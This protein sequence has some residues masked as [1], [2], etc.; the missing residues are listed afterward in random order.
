MKAKCAIRSTPLSATILPRSSRAV[1]CS[2]AVFPALVS[3][4]TNAPA[5][6]V[7]LRAGQL[8]LAEARQFIQT[9]PCAR[10]GRELRWLPF[11]GSE[12]A[13]EW[14]PYRASGQS[15]RLCAV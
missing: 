4:K 8:I 7:A 9:P 5:M 12:A 2:R 15:V 3:V 11:Q 1:A 13:A 10:R 14:L 6:G